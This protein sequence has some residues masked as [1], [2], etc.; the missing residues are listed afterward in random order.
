MAILI[1][2]G[3]LTRPHE[4]DTIYVFKE[5][6]YRDPVF[7]RDEQ[8]F[9][10]IDGDGKG[11]KDSRLYAAGIVTEEP[12]FDD[13]GKSDSLIRVKVRLTEIE[14]TRPLTYSADI[15]PH[16]DNP[17]NGVM[18]RLADVIAKKAHKKIC[19][20]GREEAAILASRFE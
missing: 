15:R 9:V 20:I 1:K 17:S 6:A 4:L 18:H 10:W 7:G 19:P 5:K 8:A 2:T 11:G 3:P 14:P 12:S 13:P 16:K